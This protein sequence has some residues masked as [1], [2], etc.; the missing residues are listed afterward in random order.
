LISILAHAEEV[1]R[2]KQKRRE[3]VRVF[4]P[5]LSATLYISK[6]TPF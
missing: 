2:E 6:V 1:Q 4:P 3:E 5:Y